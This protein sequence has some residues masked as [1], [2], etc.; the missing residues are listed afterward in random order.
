[1]ARIPEI[2]PDRLDT[3][4]L[5]AT[6][7]ALGRAASSSACVAEIAQRDLETLLQAQ[8][9]AMVTQELSEDVYFIDDHGAQTITAARAL[10]HNR[11]RVDAVDDL[12]LEYVT[13][14]TPASHVFSAFLRDLAAVG[15]ETQELAGAAKE[16]WPTLFAHVLDQV[17]ANRAI[18]DRSDSFNGY[19]LSHLLPNHPETTQSLHDEFGRHTFKWVNSDELVE[20]IPRW[21][22]YAAGRSSCLL[23]LIRFLRQL[24][25]ETQLSDGLGWLSALCL[26]RTDRQLASYAPM[27]EWLVEIKPKADARGAG[28]DWL[29]LVDRLVYAGNRTLA[30]YSR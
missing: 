14:L 22:P 27:D 7:R 12:L 21:L 24:P 25:I 5:S 4:R 17:D 3:S 1:M 30:A 19:A 6:I 20:F 9:H 18:Y 2:R 10:L 8:A 11:S 26:S 13:A 28:G 16:V 29:K 15:A 23:E